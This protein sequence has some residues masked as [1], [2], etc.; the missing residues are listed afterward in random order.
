LHTA[1][2]FYERLLPRTRAL[3]PTML[4]GAGNLMDLEDAHFAF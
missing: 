2:F 3:V 4:S 1:R